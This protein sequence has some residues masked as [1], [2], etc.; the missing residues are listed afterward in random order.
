[1]DK[2]APRWRTVA[3]VVGAIR[4]II[5]RLDVD[6]D[7][8]STPMVIVKILLRYLQPFSVSTYSALQ[9]NQIEGE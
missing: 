6:I 7:G 3:A 5:S 9:I 2:D 8:H 1:L 4:F